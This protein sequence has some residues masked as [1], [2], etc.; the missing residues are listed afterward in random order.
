MGREWGSLFGFF[1]WDHSSVVF[2]PNQMTLEI[3]SNH[4]N[5]K[6]DWILQKLCEIKAMCVFMWKQF[7]LTHENDFWLKLLCNLVFLGKSSF[8]NSQPFPSTILKIARE[9]DFQQN[10]VS[11]KAAW[12]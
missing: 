2:T 9:K 10:Q 6:T 3:L 12:Q 5:L 8:L 4:N 11:L 7:G 1:M